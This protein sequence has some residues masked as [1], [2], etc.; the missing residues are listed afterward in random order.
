MLREGSQ[1]DH[2]HD[3]EPEENHDADHGGGDPL[4]EG[5]RKRKVSAVSHSP[6]MH[7]LTHGMMKKKEG[8]EHWNE[9]DDEY[10]PNTEAQTE[11]DEIDG[12]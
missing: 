7:G 11:K 8:H 6:S 1:L 2:G 10:D 5:P 9:D 3:L 12:E 4:D